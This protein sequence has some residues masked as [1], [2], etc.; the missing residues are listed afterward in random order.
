M[1]ST[2]I[3]RL[4]VLAALLPASASAQPFLRH[5]WGVV[6]SLPA[7]AASSPGRIFTV[8]DGADTSDCT[9]GGGSS[10]VM[11]RDDGTAWVAVG[12]GG[13]GG[14]GTVT[15]VA[16]TFPNFLSV[17][18]SPIT[19]S[20][21]LAVSLAT[22]T[23]NTV[24]AGPTSGGAATPAFRG[25]VSADIPNN[26]ADT[27]GNAATATLAADLDCTG[28]VSAAELDATYL[29]DITAEDLGDLSNVSEAGAAIGEALVSDGA[30]SWGP[31]AAAAI[32]E[33]D[34]RLSD[35]RDPNAHAASHAENAA[36]ELLVEGLGTACTDGQTFEADATGG[37]VCAAAGG[38]GSSAGPSGAVQT[39][40]G[41]G[42]FTGDSD[43]VW[44]AANNE[45]ELASG[46]RFVLPSTSSSLRWYQTATHLAS[47]SGTGT[48]SPGFCTVSGGFEWVCMKP[49]A[50]NAGGTTVAFAPGSA[51]DGTS[52]LGYETT[53]GAPVM[54]D[55]GVQVARFHSTNGLTVTGDVSIGDDLNLSSD[56]GLARLGAA[57][58]ALPTCDSTT[59]RAVLFD[60]TGDLCACPP[61]GSD[62]YDTSD[63]YGLP[64]DCS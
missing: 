49:N 55:N 29:E 27:T 6:A 23:A 22:Q 24:F 10:S 43:F 34:A 48:G 25:L 51:A 33:G 40:D 17:S 28:C 52:G 9:V 14:S 61:D 18:G 35:D 62:W 45:L 59:A 58:G 31:S 50:P 21:T 19:T 1:R 30:G 3:F 39:S 16:A 12:S 57:S 44:D 47:L 46:S 15:S 64:G 63:G 53:T 7:N 36:D 8:T 2:T 60:Q 5:S 20:G 41:A 42:G 56:G 38:G 4:V 11:C 26:A 13:G 37:V 32:L 54:V